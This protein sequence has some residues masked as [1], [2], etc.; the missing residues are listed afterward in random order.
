M[1]LSKLGTS[2]RR[3][4]VLLNC[5]VQ[6][7]YIEHASDACLQAKRVGGPLQMTSDEL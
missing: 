5:T 4:L 3:L 7:L 6:V 2:G 1:R